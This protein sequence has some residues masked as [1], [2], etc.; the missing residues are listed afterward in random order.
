MG[1][2]IYVGCVFVLL[3]GTIVWFRG[4]I[5]GLENYDDVIKARELEDTI[6]FSLFVI[7]IPPIGIIFVL[8][9]GLSEFGR[10]CALRTSRRR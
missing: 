7:M 5:G 3:L 6:T 2:L 4:Y 10:W 1:W 8:A 9:L